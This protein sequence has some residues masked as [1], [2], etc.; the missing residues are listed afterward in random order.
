MHIKE[1]EYGSI[2]YQCSKGP[3]KSKKQGDVQSDKQ[4]AD[5]FWHGGTDRSTV[6]FSDEDSNE[7]QYGSYGNDGH[8]D[9]VLFPGY[10]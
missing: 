8:Y 1:A 10:V 4:A 7:D 2:L 5:L 9:A 6:I 3:D